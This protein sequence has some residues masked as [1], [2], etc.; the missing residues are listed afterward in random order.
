LCLE[1]SD[2]AGHPGGLPQRH[3]A[4]TAESNDCESS[5]HGQALPD[6]WFFAGLVLAPR[7]V[8]G[9]CRRLEPVF[10]MLPFEGLAGALADALFM[11]SGEP[12]AEFGQE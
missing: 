2:R 12:A 6:D 5:I 3:T 9:P 11:E 8:S 1:P 7:P 4:D 10:M